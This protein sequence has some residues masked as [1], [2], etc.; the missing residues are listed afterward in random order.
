MA[1]QPTG[2]QGRP[3]FENAFYRG[4]NER[5]LRIA[6]GENLNGRTMTRWPALSPRM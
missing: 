3:A 2:P 6:L 4:T 1:Q 5:I